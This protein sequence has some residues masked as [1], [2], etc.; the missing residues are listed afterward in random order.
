MVFTFTP[1]AIAMLVRQE[2]G[3]WVYPILETA[4]TGTARWWVQ[5]PLRVIHSA[6]VHSRNQEG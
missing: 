6:A 5:D 3:S 4:A 1:F 2:P